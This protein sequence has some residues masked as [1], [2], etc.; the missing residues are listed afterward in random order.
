LLE[1]KYMP[2]VSSEKL[3]EILNATCNKV[4]YITVK[5]ELVIINAMEAIKTMLNKT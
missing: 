1:K 4:L 5:V 3:A 2:I